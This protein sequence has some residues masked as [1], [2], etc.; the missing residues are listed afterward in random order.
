M[1]GWEGERRE[2]EA[3]VEFARQNLSRAEEESFEKFTAADKEKEKPPLGSLNAIEHFYQ[4]KRRGEVF[5]LKIMLDSSLPNARTQ[6][7]Q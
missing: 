7:I 4:P 1:F 6:L 3:R 5:N 2:R